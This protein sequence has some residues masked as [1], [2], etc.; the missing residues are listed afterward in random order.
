MTRTRLLGQQERGAREAQREQEKLSLRGGRKAGAL[1]PEEGG[2]Q[3]LEGLW[4]GDGGKRRG[5]RGRSVL[6]RSMCKIRQ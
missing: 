6:V 3:V 2:Q 4:R 5:G 1:A